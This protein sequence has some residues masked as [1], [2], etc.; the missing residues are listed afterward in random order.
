MT[1]EKGLPSMWMGCGDE[2]N[3]A[4]KREKNEMRFLPWASEEMQK[5]CSLTQGVQGEIDAYGR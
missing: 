1:P 5:F 4:N 3:G 2:E